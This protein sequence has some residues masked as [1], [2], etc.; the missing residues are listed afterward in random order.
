[1]TRTKKIICLLIAVALT[2][3]FIPMSAYAEEEEIIS[4]TDFTDYYGRS[5]LE[6][7][8]NSPALLYA[9]DSIASGVEA[10]LES[11][12]VYN[13]E[14]Y[15][16]VAELQIV[17][18][19]Y[20]RDYAHHFWLGKKYSYSYIDESRV[21]KYVPQYTMAGETLANAKKAGVEKYVKASIADVKNFKTPDDRLLVITNPPYGERLEE[22]A[23]MPE[24]YREIGKA[25]SRLD[26][27]SYYLITGYEDAQK[28]LG[29]TADKNRKIYN[30]M[31]KTYFY[32][33]SGPKPPK[34]PKIQ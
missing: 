4:L 19:A 30:G 9:Y 33:F 20:M 3:A 8:P 16:S 23:D 10:S 18:D 27:W 6:K 21:T 1:M 7:L 22:K 31:L 2:V 28:Y 13:G 32:Q 14:S 17:I 26:S 12:S 15:I 25:F 34:T 24:L 5:A 29:R 11:I